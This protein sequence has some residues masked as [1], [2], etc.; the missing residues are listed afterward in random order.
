MLSRNDG[1][2][3]LR[4]T[5]PG[6]RWLAGR[7]LGTLL[8][9]GRERDRL[10]Q[11]CAKRSPVPRAFGRVRRRPAPRRD[12]G[13]QPEFYAINDPKW[14]PD[15]RWIAFSADTKDR[16]G[17]DS[18][19]L[20]QTGIYIIRANASEGRRISGRAPVASGSG[21]KSL[22]SR[23]TAAASSSR[24]LPIPPRP[25]SARPARGF[26][27]SDSTGAS[28]SR[29]SSA[30]SPPMGAS[31]E[32]PKHPQRLHRSEPFKPL[33]KV[34]PDRRTIPLTTIPTD[35][36]LRAEFQGD[37]DPDWRPRRRRYPS[38]LTRFRPRPSSLTASGPARPPRGP[39]RAVAR[40]HCDAATPS[41]FA[42]DSAGIAGVQVALARGAAPARA[43]DVQVS[44][45]QAVQQTLAAVC[46]AELPPGRV[47]ALLAAAPQTTPGEAL[48]RVGSHDRRTRDN[49][50]D[51]GGAP[52]TAAVRTRWPTTSSW[53]TR[54]APG[55]GGS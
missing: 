9:A 29:S 14:S 43:G 54:T 18:A 26:T 25:V 47:G 33:V 44:R 45:S 5:P 40:R 35:P 17:A 48:P 1:R 32:D 50:T 20:F 34:Y 39:Q 22:P 12:R 3:P 42:V 51:A 4:P 2:P 8:V 6:V 38:F 31:A 24:V 15:G 19:R 10:R 52:P 21:M 46:A 55:W 16:F 23:P 37:S 11:Q 53:S 27:R 13:R 7:G 41:C 49:D 36:E 30:S 28:R